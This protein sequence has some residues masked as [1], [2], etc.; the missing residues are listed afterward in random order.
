MQRTV[1]HIDGILVGK[2]RVSKIGN[3]HPIKGDIENSLMIWPIYS[4]LPASNNL[5]NPGIREAVP[6]QL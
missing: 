3:G 6:T 2:F 4:I 5:S 1:A